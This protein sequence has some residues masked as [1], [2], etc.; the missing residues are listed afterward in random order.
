MSKWA[1]LLLS[2]VYRDTRYRSRYQV[3]FINE[4]DYKHIIANGITINGIKIR[5]Q[6]NKIEKPIRFYI[7]NLQSYLDEE[8]V[9]MLFPDGKPT[10]VKQKV[11]LA[12]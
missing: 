3:T 11:L 5:G 10:Y 7:P 4:E 8:D 1:H 12:A 2:K 9:Y 6:N